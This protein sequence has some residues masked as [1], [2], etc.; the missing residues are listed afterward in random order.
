VTETT[1][2]ELSAASY[3]A[4]SRYDREFSSAFAFGGAGWERNTFSGIQ[5]RYSIVAGLGRT[6]IEGDSEE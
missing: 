4:R 5:N 1:T 3:F 6:W 2:S